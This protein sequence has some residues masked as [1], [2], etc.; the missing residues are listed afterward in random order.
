MPVNENSF[1]AFRRMSRSVAAAQLLGVVGLVLFSFQAATP[2]AFLAVASI[3]LLL[4]AAAFAVGGAIGFIFGIPKSL[5]DVS[6]PPTPPPADSEGDQDVEGISRVAYAGNTSLEQISDWLTKIIV[7]VGLTQL[8]NVPTAL[9]A[10]GNGFADALGGFSGSSVLAALEVIFFGIGGFF[11]GYLWTRLYLVS[12]LV[13]SDQQ[14]RQ[15]AEFDRELR[16]I[17]VATGLQSVQA[18]ER[19]AEGA[20]RPPTEPHVL[21]V[22][23]RPSNNRRE[24]DQL[25]AQGIRVTPVTST[26]GALRELGANAAKYGLVIT[27]MSRGLDRRAGYTLLRQMRDAGLELPVVIYAGS[28]SL[29]RDAEARRNGA[30][31]ST[32]SPIRLFELVGQAFQGESNDSRQRR[33]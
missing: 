18:S 32:N 4:A 21:W 11:L 9:T 15:A 29:E 14:A 28:G 12:L 5:Q 20:S 24:M 2:D 3:A 19:G 7:G 33:T 6:I 26:E 23:D 1:I 13:E 30:L 27:D 22:D 31:G 25:E 8:L 16:A 10:L 17:E